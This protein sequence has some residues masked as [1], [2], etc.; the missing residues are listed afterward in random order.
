MGQKHW[1]WGCALVAVLGAVSWLSAQEK[2]A[3]PFGEP[4]TVA[5]E[6]PAKTA[7][8]KE[9]TSYSPAEAERRIERVLDQP[10]KVSLNFV[11]T[12]LRD[13]MAALSEEYEIPI[14]FDNPAL[15]AVASSPDVEVTMN[16]ANVTLRSALE[17]MLKNTGGE[18]LTYVVDKEVLLIT[19]A[20]EAEKRLEVRVYR[21]D[22]LYPPKGEP[23]QGSGAACFDSLIDVLTTCVEHPSWAENGTGEGQI[24]A[25]T[26]GILVVSQ[27][28][29]VQQQIATLLDAMRNVKEE[30]DKRHEGGF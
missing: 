3:D 11:Q 29:Q 28:R 25:L 1:V 30:I 5:A 24:S 7:P 18:A 26:P 2:A 6:A 20:E 4:G 12:P 16:I 15:D 9:K 8:V 21:V 10:L 23:H 22:D 14:Q 19:T 27:T 17:L 13:V